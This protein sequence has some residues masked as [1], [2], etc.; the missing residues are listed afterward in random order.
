ML[1]VTALGSGHGRD[2]VVFLPVNRPAGRLTGKLSQPRQKMFR[3]LGP[4]RASD[5]IRALGG[6]HVAAA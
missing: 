1:S 2:I 5:R 3:S 4:E 6:P